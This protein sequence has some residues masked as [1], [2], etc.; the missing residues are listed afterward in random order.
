MDVIGDRR[1]SEM[2]SFEEQKKRILSGQMYNDLTAELVE[3]RR[4][5]VE[6]TNE[7]NATYGQPPEKREPLLRKLLGEM[8]EDVFFEPS[9]RC[10]FGFNSR[11][12]NHF[13]ANFDCV[14]LDGGGIEI[15]DHVLF[16]PRVSI[17]TSRH[18]FDPQER[19]AG[20]C[21]AKKVK[22][23]NHV[24]VGGG[25]HMDHGITIG[26][27][28]VIGAGSVITRDIPANVVAAGAPCRVIR[29]ITEEE[30]TDYFHVLEE[31]YS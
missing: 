16:G 12:G 22:I 31:L 9:F 14:M 4:V 1:G 23:G 19:A 7:Y 26:D 20:A 3:A 10:E 25:V 6:L 27:N 28:S 2:L 29:S 24:W 15:G 30:K 11:I 5:A 13:Y 18:A 21:F 8:G 17:Y